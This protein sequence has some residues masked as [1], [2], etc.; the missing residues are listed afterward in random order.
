MI[1]SGIEGVHQPA[2]ARVA[3]CAEVVL[4]DDAAT[5]SRSIRIRS[6]YTNSM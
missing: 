1:V 6:L 4:F 5:A 3:S 2:D